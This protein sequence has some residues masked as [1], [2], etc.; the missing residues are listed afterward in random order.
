[1]ARCQPHKLQCFSAASHRL[2]FSDLVHICA[3][4]AMACL[5]LVAF[6]CRSKHGSTDSRWLLTDESGEDLR[7][8][9]VEGTTF[10]PTIG[11]VHGLTHLDRNLEVCP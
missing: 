4:H 7:E 5:E 9:T 8:L 1:M 3:S 6:A 10:D 2:G 11:R